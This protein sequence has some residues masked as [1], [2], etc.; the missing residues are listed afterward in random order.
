MI[1]IF[2]AC[3]GPGFN[4]GLKDAGGGDSSD[5]T[6]SEL[7]LVNSTGESVDAYLGPLDASGHIVATELENGVSTSENVEPGDYV[8]TVFG[9]GACAVSDTLTVAEGESETWE[10]STLDGSGSP[11][12]CVVE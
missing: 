11:P 10:A 5:E 12:D 6:L 7:S 8:W 2:I 9:A 4:A 3:I 1:L